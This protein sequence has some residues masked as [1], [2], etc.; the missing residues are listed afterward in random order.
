MKLL[1]RNTTMFEKENNQDESMK[2]LH[3][4]EKN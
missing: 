1:E 3:I 2:I 4:A